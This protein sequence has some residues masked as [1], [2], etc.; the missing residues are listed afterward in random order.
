[1]KSSIEAA[2][3]FAERLLACDDSVDRHFLERARRVA[4]AA[5][6][7]VDGSEEAARAL[8]R[9]NADALIAQLQESA[10]PLAVTEGTSLAFMSERERASIVAT[11][12]GSLSVSG[13]P[14]LAARWLRQRPAQ[15]LRIDSKPARAECPD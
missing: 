10:V 6:L 12:G 14:P 8:M 9:E 2:K 13:W 3:G 11:P 7:A 1:M 15:T 4:E 5:Y